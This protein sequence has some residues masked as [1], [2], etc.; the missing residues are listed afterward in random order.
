MVTITITVAALVATSILGYLMYQY[1]NQAESYKVKFNTI[2]EF[3]DKAGS[4]ILKLEHTNKDLTNQIV[5]MRGKIELLENRKG[6]PAM[7]TP[8]AKVEES[9]LAEFT[10]AVVKPKPRRRYKNKNK[11][12]DTNQI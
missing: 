4:Q 5:L 10:A 1:K 6:A 3:A 12:K 8:T 7:T 11:V 2:K 9:K